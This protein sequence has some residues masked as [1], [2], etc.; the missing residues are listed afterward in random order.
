MGDIFTRAADHAQHPMCCCCIV[1]TRRFCPN[2]L[3]LN[4]KSGPQHGHVGLWGASASPKGSED[5]HCSRGTLKNRAGSH[6]V[7]Q[8]EQECLGFLLRQKTGRG[9]KNS[10]SLESYFL[11]IQIL[12][13]V[14]FGLK[15]LLG[16]MKTISFEI[17]ANKSLS[18][19]TCYI[20]IPAQ[21]LKP[22]LCFNDSVVSRLP[23]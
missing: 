20:L 1:L 11:S 3:N 17:R 16:K 18:K 5:S 9:K 12:N 10:W 15:N 19:K 22:S 6:S 4:G 13:C 21:T 14:E 2:F 23:W 8:S 7:G